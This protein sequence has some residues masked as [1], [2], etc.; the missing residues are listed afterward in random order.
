[1]S[2]HRWVQYQWL[3]IRGACGFNELEYVTESG[4]S[5]A[6][7]CH[8]PYHH[9]QADIKEPYYSSLNSTCRTK[10]P[11]QMSSQYITAVTLTYFMSNPWDV[12]FGFCRNAIC[13]RG[14][15]SS[16]WKTVRI[17]PRESTF[18]PTSDP[19]YGECHKVL[20]IK[21][22]VLSRVHTYKFLL[23][24]FLVIW[25]YYHYYCYFI[26]VNSLLLKCRLCQ[27]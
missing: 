23:N 13:V 3:G 4:P 20:Y 10:Q 7:H 27:Y 2:W 25:I 19:A 16:W 17:W 12:C 1:M 14:S 24:R 21:Q 18:E 9:F 6:M 26:L 8:S 5:V 22:G 11:W 15:F